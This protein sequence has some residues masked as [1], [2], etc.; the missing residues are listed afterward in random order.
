MTPN[1]RKAA[2]LAIAAAIAIPAEGL[3]QVAYRDPPGILTVCYGSTTN[4]QPGKVYSLAECKARLDADMLAAVDAVERCAPGL[5]V[6]A[7]AAFSDAVYNIG[8]TI[9]CDKTRST[10]ARLLAVGMVEDAC[11]QLPRWNKATVAGQL[12]E[13]PGLT[14]R[15]AKEMEL[16]LRS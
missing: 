1:Q 8:P 5:P 9:A 4:V 14:K 12:V 10:A 3:R 11:R 15:R 13:L 7:L 2:A 6:N 16:C